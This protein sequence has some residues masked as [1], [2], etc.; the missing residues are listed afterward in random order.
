[1]TCHKNPS[2]SD[3]LTS[4]R[5]EQTSESTREVEALYSM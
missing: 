2:P 1:M 5:I 4:R 3:H